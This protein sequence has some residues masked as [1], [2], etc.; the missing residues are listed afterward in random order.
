MPRQG[1]RLPG[2][3]DPRIYRLAVDLTQRDPRECLFVDDRPLN[4][5]AARRVGMPAIR[6]ESAA[7]LRQELAA[8]GVPS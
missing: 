8:N 3:P 7:Q 2:K 5:A 1:S 4:V 6:F